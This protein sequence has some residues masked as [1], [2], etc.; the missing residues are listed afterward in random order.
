MADPL[1]IP[2]LAR[3]ARSRVIAELAA[4]VSGID[5]S[6]VL[7]YLIDSVNASVLPYLAEQFNVLDEGWQYAVTDAEKRRLLHKAIDL[8]RHKGTKWSVENA[9]DVLGLACSVQEWFEYGGAPYCFRASL[10]SD[11]GLPEN[12]Y[13]TGMERAVE[14]IRKTKNVRSWLDALHIV[15]AVTGRAPC[16]AASIIHGEVITLYPAVQTEFEQ[17]ASVPRVALGAQIVEDITLH[18]PSTP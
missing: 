1:L 3:D 11:K 6:P 5:L 4:R 18:P 12:F 9:L 8:H 13:T 7:V 16:I 14:I 17:R 15:L 10:V 2:A